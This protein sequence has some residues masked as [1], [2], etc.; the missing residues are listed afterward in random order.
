MTGGPVKGYLLDYNTNCLIVFV[1][2]DYSEF[3]ECTLA[4]PLQGHKVAILLSNLG[5]FDFHPK[6]TIWKIKA[7]EK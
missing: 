3:M 7:D 2:D 6:V 4:E 1:P 5:G